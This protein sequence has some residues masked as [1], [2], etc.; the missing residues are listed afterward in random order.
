MRV[1]ADTT[2]TTREKK[3]R[4][5][6]LERE[7]KDTR[8]PPSGQNGS[9]TGKKARN[10]G[11]SGGGRSGPSAVIWTAHNTHHTHT[12]HNTRSGHQP[13]HK[14]HR[15]QLGLGPTRSGP[16]AVWA[17]RGQCR[18]LH[19]GAKNQWSDT[20]RKRGNGHQKRRKRR[21][22]KHRRSKREVGTGGQ[23]NGIRTTRPQCLSEECLSNWQFTVVRSRSAFTILWDMQ[24]NLETL[25]D[26]NIVPV[27]EN[28]VLVNFFCK[29]LLHEI[30]V[31]RGTTKNL[32]S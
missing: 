27:K 14:H 12:T 4:D 5:R 15:A 2:H 24:K 11:R 25:S 32:M 9:G 26:S 3:T 10:F 19:G 7:K 17:Q 21:T 8:R 28:S 13:G 29:L 31:P 30:S 16:N 18:K 20:G 6:P 22:R 1:L 23:W